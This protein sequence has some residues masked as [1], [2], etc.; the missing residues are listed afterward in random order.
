MPT[1]EGSLG[2]AT[3]DGGRGGVCWLLMTEHV[4]EVIEVSLKYVIEV[5]EVCH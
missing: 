2:G 4:I 5:I 3:G 1:G